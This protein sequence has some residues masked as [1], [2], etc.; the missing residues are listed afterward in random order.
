MSSNKQE[1][2][3]EAAMNLFAERGYDGTTIPMIADRAGVGAGTIYR[4]F[5]NK[6][7]LINLLYEKCLL[8]FS[9][10]LRSHFPY[11]AVIR[12]QFTHI[13][14]K[15]FEYAVHHMNVFLFIDAHHEGYYLNDRSRNIYF[16]FLNFIGE[17]I[18]NGKKQG[19]IRELPSYAIISI[20]Y[21]PFVMLIQL[22]QSEKIKLTPVLLEKMKE[23]LW[24][25]IR[26]S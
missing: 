16:D 21:K 17:V 14:H 15:L 9:E 7:S 12:E 10:T 5:E 19:I 22:E 20:V 4:Y 2:I 8:H 1:D 11:D 6:Q 25:A 23:S 3:Y 24:D 13:V 26:I 18:E